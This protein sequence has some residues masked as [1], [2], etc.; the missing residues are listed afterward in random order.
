MCS[1]CTTPLR[2]HFCKIHC[3]ILPI[4][5]HSNANIYKGIV[6]INLMALVEVLKDQQQELERGLRQ[7]ELVPREAELLYKKSS[8]IQVVSGVRRCGKSVFLHQLL[9]E[10]GFAYVNFDDD[11]LLDVKPNDVLAAWYQL[12]GKKMQ[13]LFLDEI[14]NLE[15]WELFVNRLHRAGFR[16]FLT[17]SNAKLLAKEMAT[18]L[19]G[20]HHTLELFPFSFKE[21]LQAQQ[22]TEDL[23]TTQG[24]SMVMRQLQEYIQ[25]G[26]FPEIVVKKEEPGIYLRELYQKIVDRDIVSRYRVTHQKTLK[27]IARSVISSP[28]RVISLGKIRRQFGLGSDHTVK[29]Y[30]SYLEEAYLVLFLAKF[31]FKP[32]EIE[33][34]EKKAYGIDTG[35]I[36]TLSLQ[37]GNDSGRLYENIVAL[38]L[39]RRRAWHTDRELY[40]WKTAEQEEID[41]VLREGKKVVQLIQVCYDL[42]DETTRSREIRALLKASKALRCK[43]LIIITAEEE[44]EQKAMWFGLQGKVK[45]IPL[46][47]W[48]LEPKKNP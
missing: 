37:A 8:L 19:T 24:K 28:G 17:G 16:I 12:H 4:F 23:E 13:V 35:M 45:I 22:F 9:K 44:Q 31:S 14:Q 43:N 20:R 10:K 42:R 2:G 36:T 39:L 41:F 6:V 48:L 18:H 26:G 21:Y 11:R 29:N 38:E 47:K 40:Y 5:L 30:L 32:G 15:H 3:S 25:R 1:L 27:E 46:W 33:R 7:T 34:S